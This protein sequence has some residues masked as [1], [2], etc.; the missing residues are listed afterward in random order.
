[1]A[2]ANSLRLPGFPKFESVVKELSNKKELETPQYEVSVPLG[3]GCLAIKEALIEYWSK[4]ENLFST[5]MASVVKDHNAK[6]NPK[7]IKRGS[8]ATSSRSNGADEH[9]AKKAKV[10]TSVKSVD[11]EASIADKYLGFVEVP[12]SCGGLIWHSMDTS[13]EYHIMKYLL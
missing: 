11:H 9:P 3:N 2:R 12:F 7:G 4:E 10:E 5:E 13:M 6:Y 8:T 1:M